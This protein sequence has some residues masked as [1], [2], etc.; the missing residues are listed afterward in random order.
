MEQDRE[1]RFK[2]P[3]FNLEKR[4][5]AIGASNHLQM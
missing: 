1:D 3:G 4:D 5:K 2:Q